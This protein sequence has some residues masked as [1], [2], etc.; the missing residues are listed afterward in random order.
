MIGHAR[1]LDELKKLV[2][3]S[4]ADATSVCA[5]AERLRVS[6]FAY[7]T[8]HQDLVQESLT[9]TIKV[10]ANHRVGIA[11]TDTLDRTSLQRGLRAALEIARH[12]PPMKNLPPLPGPYEHITL[13]DHD[14]PTANA[15][16]H[17]VVT[18]LKPLL[19]LCQGVGA[20]L[21]GSWVA[22]EEEMAV[23][24]SNGVACYAASTVSGAKLVTMY[25]RLSG[26][27]SGVERHL[28]RLNLEELLE[29]ALTQCL[30]RHDPLMLPTGTYEVI[31]EPEAVAEL[32]TWLGYIAFGA[33]SFQERTSFL[34][35]R[36]G[37]PVMARSMT[38]TDEGND[39]E[40]LRQPFDHEGVPKQRV[41]LIDR[42]AASGIVYDTTYGLLYGHPS[43]GHAQPP[44]QTDG[45]LPTHLFLAAG[46]KRRDELIRSCRRGLLIPRFHYVNG[47]L[48]P[49]EALMTGLTREG[50]WLIEDGVPRRP[51]TTM[52]F[53]Q[54]VLEAFQHVLGVSKERRLVADPAQDAGCAVMPTVHLAKFRFT[55]R[56]ESA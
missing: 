38:I 35:G 40:G 28:S 24:N 3:R 21:A 51:V 14:E 25:R 31:L 56:S 9:V 11:V 53:T 50:A 6:R 33:K 44:D 23:V 54:S 8:I 32:V 2:K 15:P 10:V 27:A 7:E 52:R 20:T 41:T 12:A 16:A 55:G 47:L 45:P 34:F 30:S 49:R 1:L 19:R 26:Y 48:N 37:E 17:H 46:T 5:D 39:P 43:T 29:R 13:Q 22:S 4:P 36:I 18:S 42:G